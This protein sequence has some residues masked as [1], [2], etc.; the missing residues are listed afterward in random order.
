M[1]TIESLNISITSQS[2][3]DLFERIRLIRNRRRLR[4][5]KAVRAASA[6]AKTR[7]RPSKATPKPQDL[8]ALANSMSPEQRQ[9]LA[10]KLLKR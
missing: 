1:A 10:A 6:P 8:F 7:R 9:S 5:T 3:E 4:P 2:P